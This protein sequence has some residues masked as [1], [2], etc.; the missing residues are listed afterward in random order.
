MMDKR[1]MISLG[2]LAVLAVSALAV[3]IGIG[4]GQEGLLAMANTGKG[5][6]AAST[7][8]TESTPFFETYR[9]Q[10]KESLSSVSSQLEMILQDETADEITRRAAQ[11]QIM[12]L[13]REREAEEAA[14]I[15][16]TAKGFTHVAVAIHHNMAY[17]MVGCEDDAM[18]AAE[19]AKILEICQEQWSLET[20]NIKIIPVPIA[21]Y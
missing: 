15:L 12:T 11:E 19:T 16:L 3:R 5:S 4:R 7:P 6:A 2:V 8:G 1:K 10:R 13:V 18:D 17:V 9:Q 21:S 20:Q 14:E